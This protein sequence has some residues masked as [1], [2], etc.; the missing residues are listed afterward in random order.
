MNGFVPY[1]M[2]RCILS[3]SRAKSPETVRFAPVF[4]Y[5]VPDTNLEASELAFVQ[6]ELRLF[7]SVQ[8]DVNRSQE[9]IPQ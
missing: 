8:I 5:E 9:S 1:R 4:P 6:V 2:P 7:I 3:K